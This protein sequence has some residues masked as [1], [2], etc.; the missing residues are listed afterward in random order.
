MYNIYNVYPIMATFLYNEKSLY[1]NNPHLLQRKYHDADNPLFKRTFTIDELPRAITPESPQGIY[2]ERKG[3]VKSTLHYGQR[4]LLM[5]EI[6]F[7]TLTET[8]TDTKDPTTVIY[9]GAAPSIHT[10]IL[11]KMFPNHK[12]VLVDPSPFTIKETDNISI[13]NAFFTDELAQEFASIYKNN[14]VLLISDVRS[15]DIAEDIQ[16][17][18]KQQEIVT[19]DMT[20]QENWHSILKP[21][22]SMFKFRLPWDKGTTRYYDGE[23][24]FQAWAPQTSSESRLI[25][26]KNAK[27]RLYD[28]HLYE[29]HMFFFNTVTRVCYY[30]HDVQANGLDHC[31]DCS[32]E[33]KILQDYLVQYKRQKKSTI[34]PE[35]LGKMVDDITLFLSDGKRAYIHRKPDKKM[36]ND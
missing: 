29:S 6:D 9:V 25:I 4:K 24:R 33:V 32:C 18:Q 36:Y 26:K 2:R 15:S 11:S 7:L 23:I 17:V 8:D 10:P 1:K 21:E 12:F 28:N 20:M 14:R 13:L 30:E 27:K 31:Y 19:R 16:N 3:E 22:Y 34:T 5:S 35:Q